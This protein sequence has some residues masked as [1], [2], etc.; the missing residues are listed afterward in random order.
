M[1]MALA[2]LER[3]TRAV[4]APYAK[5]LRIL[6]RLLQYNGVILRSP[7]EPA[8]PALGHVAHQKRIEVRMSATLRP[9]PRARPSLLGRAVTRQPD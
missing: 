8:E 5:L 6:E 4:K 7:A 3:I 9:F 1:G 2:R